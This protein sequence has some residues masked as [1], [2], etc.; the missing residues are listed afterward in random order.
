MKQ[1]ISPKTA[2]VVALCES[3]ATCGKRSLDGTE[4]MLFKELA[5]I[6]QVFA[7]DLEQVLSFAREQR[8]V[9]FHGDSLVRG[10]D[11]HVLI[12]LARRNREIQHY[13]QDTGHLLPNNSGVTSG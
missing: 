4:S 7:N 5:R 2:D 13:Y 6:G 3:I 1:K 12:R 10:K 8:L 9:Q 11:D